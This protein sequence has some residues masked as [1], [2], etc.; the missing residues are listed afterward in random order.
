MQARCLAA[1]AAVLLLAG[2]GG[3]EA[4]RTMPGAT[5]VARHEAMV[6]ALGGAHI[7]DCTLTGA[8]AEGPWR[9][10]LQRQAGPRRSVRLLV[11][12][13][14][15]SRPLEVKHKDAARIYTLRDETQL[16]IAADGQAWAE[17][18]GGSM[19]KSHTQGWCTPG[20]QPA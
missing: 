1:A 16:T 14:A 8:A 17:G 11:A 6:A 9:F 19:G 4:P 12:G 15:P 7:W 18:P 2:C 20:E 13:Q 5:K 10:V 3:A